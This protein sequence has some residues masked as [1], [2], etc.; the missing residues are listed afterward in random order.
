[1]IFNR[2]ATEQ[3]NVV[4]AN[5]H[6]AN[7]PYDCSDITPNDD[8]VIP[9]GTFIP[10]NDGTAEGVLFADVVPAENPNGAITIHGTIDASKLP[11]AP[12]DEAKAALTGIIFINEEASE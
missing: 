11:E 4:V 12:T 5:D 8:G 3:G 10:A 9:A 7:K 6:F 2:E 1:M